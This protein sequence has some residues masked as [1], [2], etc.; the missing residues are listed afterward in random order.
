MRIIICVTRQTGGGS[1]GASGAGAPS[2]WWF[3]WIALAAGCVPVHIPGDNTANGG[4]TST[5][6][7]FTVQLEVSNPT[8][9]VDE[10]VS[11]QCVASGTFTRPLSY[12]FDSNTDRLQTNPSAGTA[13]L[14][15]AQSDQGSTILI[16]CTATDADGQEATSSA[17]RITPT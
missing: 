17:V 5:P 1:K 2:L 4:D 11:F 7:A 6:P 15:I 9:Q 8:P 13:S 12:A 16:S 14:I 10:Q 3:G